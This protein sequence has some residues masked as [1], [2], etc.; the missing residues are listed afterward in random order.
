MGNSK[1]SALY[2]KQGEKGIWHHMRL[3]LLNVS[4]ITLI[5]SEIFI[6]KMTFLVTP[7][8]C[9]MENQYKAQ[10]YSLFNTKTYIQ[11]IFSDKIYINTAVKNGFNP[12]LY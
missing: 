11:T 6:S 10:R 7:L 9:Q 12:N 2:S 8:L 4:N 5:L 1:Y 3:R